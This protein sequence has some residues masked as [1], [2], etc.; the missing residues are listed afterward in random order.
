MK[1]AGLSSVFFS[2]LTR[3]GVL[4]GSLIGGAGLAIAPWIGGSTKARSPRLGKYVNPLPIPAVARP[5]HTENG[6]AHYS[7]AMTRFRHRVH[8]DLPQTPLWGYDGTWPGPTFEVQTG[9]PISVRW[10][11]NLPVKRHLLDEAYDTTIHGADLGEPRVRT[12]VHVHGAKVM[13]DSDGYPESWFTP[14]WAQTGPYFTTKVYHYPNEQQA[15]NLWYHDHALGI[16]RLNVFSGLAG[17]YFIRDEF[18][19]RLNLPRDP[20]EVPLLIQ[21]RMFKS[22]GSLYYPTADGGT[23]DVWIPEFFGDV[24]CVNGIAFPYLE[25]EPRKYRFRLLNGSN[26]RFYHLTLVDGRKKRGSVFYQIGTD[27]GLLPTP[28]QLDELL[29]APA[30]RFDLIV[31]FAGSEGRS[32]AL[33]NDAPSPYPGGG[34]VELPEIM[35]FRVTRPLAGRDSSALPRLLR[36]VSPLPTAAA[37][38]ERFIML[39]EAD[40]ESDGFPIIGELGGSP[41]DANPANP[42]GGGR[43]D[44]PVTEAPKA[45]TVEI[46]NLVNTTTDGHPIH[47]HLVQFQILERRHFDLSHYM[48]TG[49]VRFT[50]RPITPAPNERRAW[51]DTVK[52]LPGLDKDGNVIGLV[53]RLIAKFDLPSAATADPAQ[54]YRYVYHCHILEHEDNEMMRPYDVV[55]A[56]EAAT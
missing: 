26:S 39:S 46:W 29:I 27:G 52:A 47:V 40:R 3:R 14:G 38:R 4:K 6:V 54:K 24:A 55:G 51:K 13:P 37:V 12:V 30:E 11:N 43:W 18:E 19:D 32:F 23:H 33:V 21:D 48:N 2:R 8:R 22:D 31:D 34:E 20:Y 15:T 16:T 42:T 35:Q 53:T 41:L 10:I 56:P 1:K 17:F 50:G 36:P 28:V 5:T 44:D 7:I 25:V 9:Q 45:G 49:E